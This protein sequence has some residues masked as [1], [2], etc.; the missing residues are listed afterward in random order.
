MIDKTK[1]YDLVYMIDVLEHVYDPFVILSMLSNI[2]K[3]ILFTETF[4]EHDVR[5]G[6]MRYDTDFSILQI[7]K[8]LKSCGMRK[9]KFS[10]VVFPPHYWIK[11]E[12]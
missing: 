10:G 4:G 3:S 5:R 7:N 11:E 12:Q 9:F 1:T 2:S 6:G 8:H